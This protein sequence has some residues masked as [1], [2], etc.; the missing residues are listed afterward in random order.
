MYIHILY[1]G[2]RMILRPQANLSILRRSLGTSNSNQ[3]F[4]GYETKVTNK[5]QLHLE[6]PVF[7]LP[8]FCFFFPT[9][10]Q[11]QRPKLAI[12]GVQPT[13]RGTF[14]IWFLRSQFHFEICIPFEIFA[15]KI[16]PRNDFF[17]QIFDGN[18]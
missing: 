17:Y 11:R 1:K 7:F 3:I 16:P 8:N 4:K 10:L 9:L 18:F 14:G 5:I 6:R 12:N 13:G 2:C 15:W